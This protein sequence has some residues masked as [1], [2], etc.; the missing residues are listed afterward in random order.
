MNT[1]D[2]QLAEKGFALAQR[3]L[4]EELAYLAPLIYGLAGQV[5]EKIQTLGTDGETAYYNPS[6]LLTQLS[7]GRAGYQQVR[8]CYLQMLCH[9]IL[10]H[11]WQ[12]PQG[13]QPYW[14][15][16]CDLAAALL[17]RE[18]SGESGKK[19]DN[20]VRRFQNELDLSRRFSLLEAGQL[21]QCVEKHRGGKKQLTKLAERFKAD[22]H[23][24]W[25]SMKR[26]Q[27]SSNPRPGSGQGQ[28]RWLELLESVLP[29]MPDSVEKRML[30]GLLP[31]GEGVDVTAAEE[32]RSDY[33]NLLRQYTQIKELRRED[34]D[35]LDYGWY[36]LGLQ[37][38]G[39][40]PL[41]EYPESCE[42]PRADHIVI[43]LDVSGSC[44]GE[45]ARRFLR[46][47]VNMLRD[48]GVGEGN[49]DILVM[50]CDTVI[51]GE[52][53][54]HGLEDLEAFEHKTLSGFGGTDFVPVFQRIEELREQNLLDRPR[55]LLYLSDGY[56]RYPDSPPDYDVIFVLDEETSREDSPCPDWVKTVW[57][58]DDN[59][60]EE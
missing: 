2:I 13:K 18:F 12:P 5:D 35:A 11:I 45:T 39:N 52:T 48:L 33:R 9:C 42:Q 3:L 14:N 40:V 60:K 4:T 57:L 56:G 19:V 10:G 24:R 47:T 32:N 59:M 38:Y 22:D 15:S 27:T 34:D 43:A 58:T 6:W 44:G 30:Y 16:A 20:Q 29:E 23:S 50:E 26:R 51:Q 7:Q 37:L 21:I 8:N 1:Q 55:C 31:G 46:E 41:I 49:T 25:P 54:V 36:S 53:K 28:G 17:G